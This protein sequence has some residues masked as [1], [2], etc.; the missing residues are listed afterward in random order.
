MTL[1]QYS[2]IITTIY[3][4]FVRFCLQTFW[5]ER[6]QFSDLYVYFFILSWT[7]KNFLFVPCHPDNGPSKI[8]RPTRKN[9]SRLKINNFSTYIGSWKSVRCHVYVAYP[10]LCQIMYFCRNF[11]N[12][13]LTLNASVHFEKSYELRKIKFYFA[14]SLILFYQWSSSLL[15]F[16]CH[17]PRGFRGFT[18]DKDSDRKVEI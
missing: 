13:K 1:V 7:K 2:I 4:L 17:F 18:T 6:E 11:L 8:K 15:P 9:I 3:Y 5:V 14:L 12:F 10:V 16:P